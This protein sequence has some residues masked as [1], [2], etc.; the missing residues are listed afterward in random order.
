MKCD[1]AVIGGGPAGIGAAVAAGS[2]GQDVVL[3]ERHP[4]LGGM[5]TAGLVTV[6]CVAHHDGNRFIIG[7]V[8]EQVRQALIARRAIYPIRDQR[9]SEFFAPEGLDQVAQDLCREAG[10][11]LLL[12]RSFQSVSSAP[13]ESRVVLDD[14]STLDARFVVD[15]TGDAA[16][17]H[18]AGVETTFGRGPDHAVMPLT[19]CF[20]VGPV[21]VQPLALV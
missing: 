1:I 12:G 21:A 16:V 7:G 2:M 4:V 3:V 5:G 13:G 10:V 6:F 8:F 18:A 20:T 9:R 17:A 15:A 11:R 19:Y 14:G